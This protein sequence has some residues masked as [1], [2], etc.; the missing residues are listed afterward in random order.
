MTPALDADLDAASVERS[1][2]LAERLLH[3]ADAHR[4]RGDRRRE[5]RLARLVEHPDARRLVL[6]LT[7][8]VLRIRRPARAAR[9]LADLARGGGDGG[10]RPLDRL[11]LR[12]GSRLA[13][14]VPGAVL[15][16]VTAR[17]RGEAA[18][19]TRPADDPGF[20]RY[21]AHRAAE[22]YALNV[23]LLGEAVLGD[24]EA[25]RRLDAVLARLRRPDV[26][27]VSV[28]L[29]SVCAQLNVLAFEAEVERAAEPL[30]R[31]L[32]AAAGCTPPKLVTLDME[33]HRDLE[34]TVA[35]FRRVLDEPGLE[36]LVAGI[37]IQAYLPDAEAALLELAG[38]AEDRCRR[39][40][41]PIRVRLVKGANLSM[42]RVEAALNGWPQAPF[43]SKAEV[44]ASYKRLLDLVLDQRWGGA[45][46]VGVGS[47]NLFDVAWAMVQR[48]R[49]GATDRVELEML[50]GMA[51]PEAAAVRDAAGGLLLYAPVVPRQDF[52]AAVAYLARRLE[53]N[54]APEHFLRAL[55][56]QRQG[57]DTSLWADER[58]RFVESVRRR[59]EP[60][61]DGGRRQD[62]A[63]ERHGEA[64][65]P[66]AN[67]PDTDWSQLA[68][69]RWIAD[70]LARWW[71]APV[72]VV[73]AVV[74]GEEVAQPLTGTSLDPS[75]P[76]EPGYRY[77]EADL[78][79][80]DLAVA[81]AAAGGR[82]WAARPA[83]ERRAIL[84]RV[85]A[86]LA[87]D[88]GRLL[89]CMA[90]DAGKTVLE[91]DPEVSEAIDFARYYGEQALELDAL[92]AEG[93]AFEPHGVVVVAAP[94]N[95]PLAIPAGGVLAA[96]AA[97]SGV[98]LKPAPETVLTARL[99][100]DA[101]WGAGVPT[102]VLQFLPCDDGEVGRHLITSPGVAA[103]VLTGAYETARLFQGWRPR[104]ALHAETSGKNAVVITATADL[105]L[106][107]RDLVRAAFG[108]AGQ[109]CSAASL[110][111]VE[112]GVHDDPAFS[113]RLRDAVESLA[114]GPA[115][116]LR[117]VVG[118]LIRPPEGALASALTELGPGERWL[119]EPRRLDAT[120]HL[121][122][123]G[124]KTG[125]R[126]GSP[127]HLTECFGPVLGVMR[128]DDLDHA[129]ELQNAVP[130]GLTG[131][132]F[133]LDPA[134][135]ARW[136]ERVEVG[137]A[138]V[139]RHITGAI[140]RRQPFGGWK[141]SAVGTTRKAGGPGYVASLGRWTEVGSRPP[142]DADVSF[143]QAWR[144]MTAEHDPSALVVERN[145]LRCLPLPRGVLVRLGDG[146]TD[147]DARTAL[148][149]ARVVGIAVSVSSAVGR[150]LG[151]VEVVVEHD[152]QLARRLPGL[153][154]DK[155]RLLGSGGDELYRA[156]VDAELELD[157]HPVVG[158]GRVELAH[159]S[160]E[161]SV[162]ETRHRYGIVAEEIQPI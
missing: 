145:G 40:G 112:A 12:V 61:E 84:A 85:A 45:I 56:L 94:W 24:A 120:G 136:L 101:C 62:R 110:A 80:V 35:T 141:R 4:T 15:P 76:G 20:A 75:A 19:V 121:W 151:E 111:I 162:S 104:L 91:G 119:V 37:A 161:Q 77:V 13:S 89:A 129:I 11:A 21:A 100:A 32:H 81:T 156:A 148:V 106:A 48:E 154:L 14:L 95:F 114:V 133:A 149:A 87:D 135:V 66:F 152:E 33:E 52:D 123:P 126:P 67:A 79:T 103:V 118:P 137:N 26:A 57:R 28:K 82:T 25:A 160:R 50:E 140:V 125:V 73:T 2:E 134:E 43:A 139:N 122:R 36:Q 18:P 65:A 6:G 49:H 39:G 17:V 38:W 132:I 41:A 102:D 44:D 96:L 7:D 72:T 34:L 97:G 131:G 9:R 142:A 130:F 71:D 144:E 60:L 138:Y 159:W 99:L 90:T 5:A 153:A 109:K 147:D 107:V 124:V 143:R 8:E 69:R 88:R 86:R 155:V 113:N 115:G 51:E 23:N 74:G 55:V 63:T 78:A 117:S 98:V 158:V 22:G 27:N 30:R 47:H 146:A 150:S 92:R 83:A 10:L 42:E 105:D 46:R 31:L 108:H 16:L 53:E 157:D 68:N 93:L 1:V 127:F 58:R 116:D 59:H 3:D 64:P 70:E 128:A 54:A 29:S